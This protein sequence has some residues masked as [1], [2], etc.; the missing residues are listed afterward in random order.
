MI[1]L[2]QYC[3]DSHLDDVFIRKQGLCIRTR[4][5]EWSNCGI[6]LTFDREEIRL[7]HTAHC[8]LG[9]PLRHRYGQVPSKLGV[10]MLVYHYVNEF[11]DK[12][13]IGGGT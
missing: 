4:V 12:N 5:I 7:G 1:A 13:K 6:I 2:N 10:G 8:T 11:L 9:I 3:K